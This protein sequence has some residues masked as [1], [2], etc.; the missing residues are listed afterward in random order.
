MSADR[1]RSILPGLGVV[2]LG[3]VAIGIAVAQFVLFADVPGPR[4]AGAGLLGMSA[5]TAAYVV[6]YAGAGV[7][8]VALGIARVIRARR[9]D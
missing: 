5:G 8:L 4:E 9:G 3:L 7:V 2:A 6:G 1:A